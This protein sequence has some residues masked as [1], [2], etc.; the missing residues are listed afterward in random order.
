MRRTLNSLGMVDRGAIEFYKTF[1]EAGQRW[2][3]TVNVVLEDTT[4][5]AARQEVVRGKIGDV[6]W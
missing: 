6:Q 4:A 3:P 1:K 5:P 2:A